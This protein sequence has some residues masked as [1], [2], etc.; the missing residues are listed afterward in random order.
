MPISP[1]LPHRAPQEIQKY[2]EVSVKE[3]PSDEGNEDPDMSVDVDEDLEDLTLSQALELFDRVSV[4]SESRGCYFEFRQ[5]F[6]NHVPRKQKLMSHLESFISVSYVRRASQGM[7]N[8]P[9]F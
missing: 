8:T 9:I 6:R 5:T 7:D 2:E 1:I 4:L 3:E